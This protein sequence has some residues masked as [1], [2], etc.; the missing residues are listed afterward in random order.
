M[1]KKDKSAKKVSMK[2]FI[3]EHKLE[4]PTTKGAMPEAPELKPFDFDQ[5]F[6]DKI[7][8]YNT[9]VD[10]LDIAYLNLRPR[11]DVLVRVFLREL[12]EAGEGIYRSNM[13][14][15]GMRTQSGLRYVGEMESPFPYT[16][17][18]VVIGKPAF[19]GDDDI[20]VGDH[21]ILSNRP[22][23]ALAS[24]TGD[25]AHLKIPFGFVHPELHDSLEIP[26]DPENR[27]YGYLLVPSQEIKFV[28]NKTKDNE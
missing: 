14:M 25:N 20:K 3:N 6:Q 23:Q 1:S 21:V 17:K 10:I 4:G 28:I 11:A 12:E 5:A 16:Q 9:R 24:G 8:E 19:I 27:N 13:E 18:A 15:V 2:D 22:V 7:K 26:Q